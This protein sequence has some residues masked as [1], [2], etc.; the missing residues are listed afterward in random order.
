MKYLV[1]AV[2]H[3]LVV[4]FLAVVAAC[5]GGVYVDATVPEGPPPDIAITT[6]TEVAYR[7]D[8]IRLIGAVTASNGVDYVS[9]FRID[10]G[11]AVP[12]ETVFRP[13]LQLDTSIP[14]NTSLRLP[15]SP[16]LDYVN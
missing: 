16:D 1:R 11:V 9:F 7:G 13:P 8:P 6:S 12:L 3:A 4:P 14:V 10:F 15:L 2:R 5:G